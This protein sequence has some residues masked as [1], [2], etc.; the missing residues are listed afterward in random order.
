MGEKTI[1]FRQDE[2]IDYNEQ[3]IVKLSPYT[4]L[5]K[6]LK[7]ENDVGEVFRSLLKIHGLNR[8]DS[9]PFISLTKNKKPSSLEEL[10]SNN[11]PPLVKLEIVFHEY[12]DIF[13]EIKQSFI[14]IFP[15]I[16]DLRFTK[17]K[18]MHDFISVLQIKE[19]GVKE[20]ICRWNISKGMLK[21]LIQLCNVFLS[22]KGSVILIDEVENSL[23]HCKVSPFL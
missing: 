12:N 22:S 5:I 11:L 19:T 1:F 10:K 9:Q 18:Q 6:A 2:N 20:W 14:N 7:E 3:R 17:S 15:R 13:N 21:T 23:V 4:S 8:Q 16:E